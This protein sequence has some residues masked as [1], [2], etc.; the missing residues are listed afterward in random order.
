[1]EVVAHHGGRVPEE[2]ETLRALPGIGRYT[3]GAIA[4]VAYGKAAPIVDGNVKRV[5]ARLFALPGEG[6]ALERLSWPIA[7][8]LVRGSSPGDLNQALMELGAL[9]CTPKAPACA[10]CPV[11]ARCAAH[12]SGRQEAFPAPAPRKEVRLV[13]VAAAWVE[14]RGRILLV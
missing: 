12:A 4:S 7:E 3:A 2:V 10:A 1:A 11:A 9:I 6:A 14:R 8:T 5:F 13:R